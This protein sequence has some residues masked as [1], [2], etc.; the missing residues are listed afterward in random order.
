MYSLYIDNHL[1]HCIS[2]ERE[3]Q[4]REI[5]DGIELRRGEGL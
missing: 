3:V 4:R 2:S 1:G 5:S